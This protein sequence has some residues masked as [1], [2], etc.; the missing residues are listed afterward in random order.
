MNFGVDTLVTW[1][2]HENCGESD[3]VKDGEHN[4]RRIGKEIGKD[5]FR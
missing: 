4:N 3:L 1:I 2:V 5:R